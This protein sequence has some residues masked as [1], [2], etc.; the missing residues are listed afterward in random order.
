MGPLL[1]TS[2]Q[3]YGRL[4]G[5]YMRE[6]GQDRY[7][8][9]ALD[10]FFLNGG[11]RCY[12]A[13]VASKAATPASCTLDGMIRVQAI[14]PGAWGNRVSVEVG[15]VSSGA[16]ASASMSG[17][18]PFTLTVRYWASGVPEN[19]RPTVQE[20]YSILFSAQGAAGSSEDLIMEASCLV[21]VE[22]VGAVGRPADSAP[23]LLQGGSDGPGPAEQDFKD[24]LDRLDDKDRISLLSHPEEKHFPR[25]T[26]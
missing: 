20:E 14:G 11:K 18:R 5:G 25:V 19:G 15:T 16:S 21:K 23:I 13:R 17:A 6:G 8:A 1:I 4:F 2:V 3:E 10:G 22:R 12:I 7:L 24:A 9:Y 26:G